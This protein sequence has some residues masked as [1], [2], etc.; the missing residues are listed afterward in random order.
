LAAVLHTAHPGTRRLVVLALVLCLIGDVMLMPVVDNFIGGLG[1][2]LVGHLLFGVASL[3]RSP[4]MRCWGWAAFALVALVVVGW[5]FGRQIVSF[6]RGKDPK[7]GV[8][9]SAYLGVIS[10]MAV[11]VA[12]GGSR[13]AIVGAAFF[14]ASDTLLGY[15]LFVHPVRAAKVGVMITYHFALVGLTLGLVWR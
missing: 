4:H 14:V 3:T 7:M 15:D 5:L 10:L 13:L 11:L 6:A 2:F 9:V 1:A 12:L 8:A